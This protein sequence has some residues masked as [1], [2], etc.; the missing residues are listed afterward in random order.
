[1]ALSDILLSWLILNSGGL[2]FIVGSVPTRVLIRKF[3]PSCQ[4]YSAR[5]FPARWLQ[6]RNVDH[7][8]LLSKHLKPPAHVRTKS[9]HVFNNEEMLIICLNRYA[10]GESWDA[11]ADRFGD[12]TAFSQAFDLF[13]DHL[14]CSCYHRICGD[15][16]CCWTPMID[17]L[18]RTMGCKIQCPCFCFQRNNYGLLGS[19]YLIEMD[20]N[21]FT[22]YEF[23]DATNAKSCRI[24]AE[25]AQCTMCTVQSDV[26]MQSLYNTLFSD[27]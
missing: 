26:R 8:Q 5:W 11:I 1:M 17:T 22:T 2:L 27:T 12:A 19:N 14:F 15:S 18:C 10:H 6:F 21:D 3:D 7:L 4:K 24:D 25:L 20:V 23:I 9:G 13:V 16:L